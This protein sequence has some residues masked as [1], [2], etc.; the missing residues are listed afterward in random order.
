[1]AETGIKK[2]SGPLGRASQGRPPLAAHPTREDRR[3]RRP[4]PRKIQS[5]RLSLAERYRTLQRQGVE[6][7]SKLARKR[8]GDFQVGA[9]KRNIANARIA[10]VTTPKK[11]ILSQ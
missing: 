9:L 2:R 8:G 3:R 11:G 5:Q 4:D 1:M 10:A 6:Q 7:L